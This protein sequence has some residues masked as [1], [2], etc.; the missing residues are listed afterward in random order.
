MKDYKDLPLGIQT[1]LEGYCFND[2]HG[3]QPSTLYNNIIGTLK[4]VSVSDTAKIFAV[5]MSLLE[6]IKKENEET[7]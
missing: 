1:M 5:S 2:K 6:M 4:T 3:L 7:E